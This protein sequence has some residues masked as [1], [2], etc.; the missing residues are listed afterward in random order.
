MKI[1]LKR[2][3]SL[4]GTVNTQEFWRAECFLFGTVLLG[5]IVALLLGILLAAL[6]MYGTGLITL[7]SL[8]L[9]NLVELLF[10]VGAIVLW[11]RTG[12]FKKS[13]AWALRPAASS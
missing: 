4:S 11:C 3:F 9:I 5:S 13:L 10:G 2:F 7:M 12:I 6:A 1:L 8:P